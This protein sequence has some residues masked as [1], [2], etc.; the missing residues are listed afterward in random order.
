MLCAANCTELAI[1][2]HF[3]DY[4]Q[5]LNITTCGNL[6]LAA[7]CKPQM[8]NALW[9]SGNPDITGLGVSVPPA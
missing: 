1:R 4:I 2:D 6:S 3:S 8:C 9:G 5:K 7:I